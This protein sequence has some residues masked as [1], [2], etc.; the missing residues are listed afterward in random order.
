MFPLVY[1]AECLILSYHLHP[2][3]WQVCSKR[4]FLNVAALSLKRGSSCICCR[5]YHKTRSDSVLPTECNVFHWF[6]ESTASISLCGINMLAFVMDTQPYLEV[7][8]F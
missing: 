3:K 6:L 8:N 4:F 1:V 2:L 7:L 5:L